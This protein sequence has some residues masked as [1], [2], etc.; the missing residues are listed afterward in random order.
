LDGENTATNS[1]GPQ[2]ELEEPTAVNNLMWQQEG[3]S[4]VPDTNMA[5]DYLPVIR[6]NTAR[7][8]MSQQIVN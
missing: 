4:H 3:F 1:L 6:V 8:D 7:T 5:E 2:T